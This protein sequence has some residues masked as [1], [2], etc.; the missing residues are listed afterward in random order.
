MVS[1]MAGTFGAESP[2]HAPSLGRSMHAING[3]AREWRTWYTPLPPELTFC[4]G[5]RTRNHTRPQLPARPPT[6]DQKRGGQCMIKCTCTLVVFVDEPLA[7]LIRC[8][9]LNT[10]TAA[11]SQTPNSSQAY[12]TVGKRMTA[13]LLTKTER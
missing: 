2:S 9:P 12:K 10:A 13:L 4:Y 7:A 3:V 5:S 11:G 8:V 6:L 1:K